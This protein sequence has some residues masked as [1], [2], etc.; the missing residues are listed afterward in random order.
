MSK[1]EWGESLSPKV[2]FPTNFLIFLT[3]E[4]AK[5]LYRKWRKKKWGLLNVPSDYNDFF[6]K[7]Y[8]YQLLFGKV[9]K[10]SNLSDTTYC[11]SL[12]GVFSHWE[13]SIW[14][15]RVPTKCTFATYTIKKSYL[16]LMTKNGNLHSWFQYLSM[17]KNWWTIS[18]MTI[19]LDCNFQ[20]F[21][22]SIGVHLVDPFSFCPKCA[23]V[24]YLITLNVIIYSFSVIVYSKLLS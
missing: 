20:L 12:T 2:Y 21:R 6:Q 4:R 7:C 13:I 11:F 9:T 23:D 8:E 22:E 15:L 1:L 5:I 14:I 18:F 24:N 17:F 3:K 19:L 10:I 16:I